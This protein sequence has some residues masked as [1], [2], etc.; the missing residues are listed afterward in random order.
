MHMRFS[1]V[2]PILAAAMGMTA[3]AQ[4]SPN[5]DTSGNSQLSG[6]YYFR[7]VLWVVGYDSG[8]LGDGVSVY[9]T[10][11][12]DGNGNYS[13]TGQAMDPAVATTPQTFGGSG[14]PVTGTYAVSASG[15]GYLDN[16]YVSGDTVYGLVSHGTFIGST[17]E[18]VV[19]SD[20]GACY[21]DLFIATPIGSSEATTSS[22]NGSY[23]VFGLDNPEIGEGG[24]VYAEDYEF[25]F[26]ANGAGK[27]SAVGPALGFIAGNS[28]EQT[29][30][31]VGSINYVASNG[32]F[33]LEFTGSLNGGNLI[34]GG[35]YLYMSP[36]GYFV[37]G[38]EPNGWDMF[39]G[40]K[41]SGGSQ[42]F[43]GLYYDAGM[44]ADVYATAEYGFTVPDSYYGSLVPGSGSYLYHQRLSNVFNLAYDYT[45]DDPLTSSSGGLTDPYQGQFYVMSG[46]G[47]YRVGIG[48]L[49]VG[50]NIGINVGIQAPT[51]SG[52][53]VYVNPAG[54]Q[55]SGN[56]ALFTAGISPGSVILINGS[57]F[58]SGGGYSG[59]GDLP[60]QLGGTSVQIDGIT[61]PLVY[62]TPTL[63]AAQVPFEVANASSPVLGIQVFAS[64]GQSNLVTLF[65]GDT[66]PGA[67]TQNAEAVGNA[68]AYHILSNG[69]FSPV[70][71]ANPAVPG[72]TLVAY[73][74]GLGTVSPQVGDGV[75]DTVQATTNF[76][77]YGDLLDPSTFDVYPFG[78]T[79][80]AAADSYACAT[81]DA[82]DQVFGAGCPTVFAGLA[83]PYAG[84]Y[85]VNFVV[86]TQDGYGD[87]LPTATM[88]MEFQG[89][90]PTASYVESYNSQALLP[91]SASGAAIRAADTSALLHRANHPPIRNRS[92]HGAK[93]KVTRVMPKAQAQP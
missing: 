11:T 52:S 14:T 76:P 34:A 59:S 75:P 51:F 21:N 33:Q 30:Q 89:L 15:W 79:A 35:H 92:L 7:H 12:F 43:S 50:V 56:Y 2:I 28:G 41:T 82:P 65:E 72:E 23:T 47:T 38:G 20:G 57:G 37:F 58:G 77:I 18:Q 17:T 1:L 63:I 29:T 62:V 24:S 93:K 49:E 32:A 86:P 44:D 88:I 84:L 83:P 6:T 55:A 13:I 69:A 10:I 42:T 61:A 90:D 66:Q 68:W 19:C 31:S 64:T 73:L 27:I 54:I 22:L 36:D 91:V 5:W 39:V 9:G 48:N 80:T 3:A 67:Y 40:V 45:A 70:T 60:T 4:T 16:E 25:N 78:V 87:A 85:Q 74:N 46:N 8:D 71:S 53:G 26:T 81:Q